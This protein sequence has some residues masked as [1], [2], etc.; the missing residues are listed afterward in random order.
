MPPVFLSFKCGLMHWFGEGR[1]KQFRGI[2]ADIRKVAT[3]NLKG[4]AN[5]KRSQVSSC[6]TV[7]DRTPVCTQGRQLKQWGGL[8]SHILPTVLIYYPLT[9]V[10]LAPWR[11]LSKDAILQATS[12]NIANV[13]SSHA[14]ASSLHD[15]HTASHAEV[16]KVCWWWRK[17]GGKLIWTL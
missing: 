6:M 17:H 16:G 10:F 9:S 2:Y 3:T 15:H 11:M 14:S 1:H 12:W 13:Q 4:A 5:R 7:P 8:F